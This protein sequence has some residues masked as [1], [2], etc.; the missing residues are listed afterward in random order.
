[1]AQDRQPCFSY[2]GVLFPDSCCYTISHGIS[3]GIISATISP[4]PGREIA[5]FGDFIFFDGVGRVTIPKCRLNKVESQMTDTGEVWLLTLVDRRWK[6][7]ELGFINGCYNQ[8]DPRGKL[9][10][11]TIKSPRELAETCLSA[12]GESN[13]R[14]DM[15]PGLDSTFGANVNRFLNLGEN[16]PLSGVNPPVN[17]E[18]EPPAQAL[19]KVCDQFGRRVIYNLAEDSIWILPV[20]VGNQLP[21]GGKSLSRIGP[22]LNS[23]ETPDGTMVVGAPTKYQARFELR[24]VGEEFD[25]SWRPIDLL[26]YAPQEANGSPQVVTFGYNQPALGG[27]L[28]ITINGVDFGA[29]ANAGA[30]AAFQAAIAASVDVRIAGKVVAA[31][32]G[33]T[34]TVTGV[35]QGF[36]SR[37]TF[38]FENQLANNAVDAGL[39]L[40]ISAFA[41]STDGRRT[42]ANCGPFND[43]SEV[44]ATDNLTYYQARALARKTVWRCYQLTGNAIEPESPGTLMNVPGY[45]PVTRKQDVYLLPTQVQQVVPDRGLSDFADL[46]G[47]VDP[48]LGNFQAYVEN[49]YNGFSRDKP[50]A[51]YGSVYRGCFEGTALA[52][53]NVLD[54][55]TLPGSLVP[56]GITSIDP[57]YQVVTLAQPV[58]VLDVLVRNAVAAVQGV[59]G[60]NGQIA[61]LLV[62]DPNARQYIEPKLYLQTGCYVRDPNTHQFVAFTKSEAFP[63]RSGTGFAVKRCPDL[64]L[65]VYS[66]YTSGNRVNNTA[67]LEADPLLRANY[68]LS[69]MRLKYQMVGALTLEYN[70]LE[71]IALDGAIMQVTWEVSD[72][73]SKTVASRNCEHA[74]WVP[75]YHARR[76]IEALAAIPPEELDTRLRP[77]ASNIYQPET[78][79]IYEGRRP[80]P[81][82]NTYGPLRP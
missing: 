64:Q 38:S 29:V 50:A 11:W 15:P 43:Y 1:M 75:Q 76:R 68:Y 2:P 69:S 54:P 35:G 27:N 6:W 12:M 77:S 8:L 57:D 78:S 47:D 39:G 20:G 51:I 52:W 25:G 59:L 66:E 80:S 41:Q 9:I 67:I 13:A 21:E 55:H 81:T 24:A 42:W 17:W 10:P 70:G 26:S 44:R 19:Q 7:K 16:F 33:A 32:V 5:R 14:V 58:Y 82:S 79:N 56:I 34:L 3:P 71:A 37:F 23:V 72:R 61:Q 60:L 53:R 62:G 49:L 46:R 74:T 65:C 28:V 30:I 45:G 36:A 22:S 18:W 4:Q 63:Q 73:G 31:V 40:F 48:R